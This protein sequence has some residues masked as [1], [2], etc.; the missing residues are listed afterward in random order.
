MINACPFSLLLRFS[1]LPSP[2]LL[3]I[4]TLQNLPPIII[5]CPNFFSIWS[6]HTYQITTPRIQPLWILC[7][8]MYIRSASICSST[9]N[10]IIINVTWLFLSWIWGYFV[11]TQVKVVSCVDL[12]VVS[13]KLCD[14]QLHGFNRIRWC[15]IPV[16]LLP[17]TLR[18]PHCVR[19]LTL[20]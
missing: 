6:A 13:M 12:Y 16:A 11:C 15:N 14:Q 19:V 3:L 4:H 7:T 8:Y 9:S 1:S 10:A 5:L 20:W 2:S 18:R 17:S